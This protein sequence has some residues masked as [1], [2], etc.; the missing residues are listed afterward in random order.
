MNASHRFC[1]APMMEWTDRH[2]RYLARLMSQQTFLYTEMV[3]SLALIHGDRTRFLAYNEEEH[4][5][6]LQLG[7]NQAKQ[8]AQAAEWGAEAGFDEI[9]INVG[10]P[11]DRVQAGGFGAYLMREPKRV[12][13]CV[14]AMKAVTPTPITVKCRLG[15]DDDDSYAFFHDFVSEVAEAGTE[16][17]IVHARKALLK[18]LNPKQNREIPELQYDKV[19]R[20]KQDFPKLEIILNGGVKSIPEMQQHLK[21]VDG[22][23]IGREAYKH[24]QF[25]LDID[26]VLFDAD[27][28]KNSLVDVVHLYCRYMDDKL[29]EGVPLNA[30]AKHLLSLFQGVPGAKLWRRHLSEH[31]HQAGADTAVI[32]DALLLMQREL[33]LVD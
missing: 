23:M 28:T 11:S 20:I 31:I 2:Y 18:G 15:V 33:S 6:A 4:P 13:D 7:G 8:M 14:R 25:L 26:R 21:Q 24:P 10:C 29:K 12:A 9:N 30:M 19:Y 5:V 3:T 27:G 1:I 17:F 32:E 16:L 22:V